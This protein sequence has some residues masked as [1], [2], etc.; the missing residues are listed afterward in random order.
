MVHTESLDNW[1]HDHSFDQGQ[2]KA[3]ET[4]TWLVIALTGSMMVVEIGAGMW[5]GSMALLADG[6]HMASHS[7]AL[8]ITAGAY[9]YARRHATDARFAFGTGKVNSLA[10]FTGAILLFAFALVMAWESVDRLANP[11][12][13]A[14]SEAILVAALGLGVNVV[15]AFLLD[16]DDEHSRHDHN[17]RSAYLHVLA[18][19]LTS[20]LAI[21]ALLS[22][23]FLGLSWMDP[24]MGLVGA[25]LVARWSWG[26]LGATSRVLLDYQAPTGLRREIRDAVESERGNR[27]SDLH[28]WSI[29]P[30]RYAGIVSIVTHEPRAPDFYKRLLPEDGRL[31][32]MTVEVQHCQ[33]RSPDTDGRAPRGASEETPHSGHSVEG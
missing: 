33:A 29:A 25:A 11:V 24:V 18:D 32:H 26:L 5:S 16:V 14:F 27:V 15:S 30:G 31:A 9:F 1:Q 22:A 10:G 3:G 2:V 13:I 6:L 4:R 19:A 28:V 23:K 21:F 20:V 12:A 8:A 17:L 7:A